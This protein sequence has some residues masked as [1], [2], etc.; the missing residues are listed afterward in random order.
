MLR[1]PFDK[2]QRERLALIRQNL[3][4]REGDETEAAGNARWSWKG[5]VLQLL[6]SGVLRVDRVVGDRRGAL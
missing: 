5:Y 6:G 4:V 3:A 2:S 1:H